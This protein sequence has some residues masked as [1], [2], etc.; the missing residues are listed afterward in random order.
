M[1]KPPGWK[2]KA[3]AAFAAVYIVWGSTYLAIRI[4]VQKLPPALFAGTRFLAAGVLLAAYARLTGQFWPR[5]TTEWKTIVIVGVLLLIGGNGLVVWGSQWIASNQ[6]ALIVAT[7][8]LWIAGFGT[9][10]PQG[11]PL[12]RQALLGLMIGLAG[13]G[14]LLKPS[15]D[16]STTLLW[17]QISI[18]GAALLWATGTIYGKRRRPKTLPLMSAAM[19]SLTAGGLLCAA[20]WLLG[21]GE[22]WTWS[23]TGNVVL[24]Y[25]IVFGALAFAA[26]VWLV[27]EVTPAALGTYAY[28]NPAIAVVLGWW[29][30]D[31]HLGGVQILG[32]AT[33]LV[34]VVL[35]STARA[36]EITEPV[37]PQ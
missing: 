16:F 1:H 26:Y 25:L 30:L 36:R 7:V 8:A 34:G 6:A 11:Q 14:L 32:M 4:G 27:H 37:H 9:L 10:G 17:G 28:V 18:L 3:V 12:P 21:E 29:V 23:W 31:E 20:G 15:A 19:Q 13:V 5:G 2:L 22:A 33:I 24:A 35:V